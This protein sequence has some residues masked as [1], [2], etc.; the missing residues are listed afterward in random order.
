MKELTITQENIHLLDNLPDDLQILYC[1]NNQ[2]TS[3]P[4]LPKSLQILYC[5]NNQLTSLPELQRVSK[6]YIV[7]IIN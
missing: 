4:K 7:I 2:L 3:L 5:Y 6:N 1:D